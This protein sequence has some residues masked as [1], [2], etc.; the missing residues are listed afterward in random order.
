MNYLNVLAKALYDNVAESPDE[1][2]FRKG[3]IMTVLERD[4]QG[5]DGW[6][7]CSLHGR[8]GI[9]PGNRLKLL[10]GMYDS[11]QQ[12]AMP[13]TPEPASCPSSIQ[14]P[15]PPLSAYA[16]PSPATS[17][18]TCSS[19]Y[20]VKPL[21]SAQYTSMHPAYSSPAQP[22][23]DS[24]YMMPPSHG[25]K[26]SPQSVYQIP[27][28]P[29]GLPPGPP[30]KTSLA[31]R[32]Y[33]SPGQDIYQVPPSLGPGPG[34]TG[35]TGAGQDVYQVPPSMEKRNWESSTKP[36][37]KV[38]VPT[39]VGQVYVY[40]TLKSD[41][42][43]YDVP[44]RHQPP[45]QQDIYDVPPTRQ[46]YNT[47]V[48]DTPPMVVKGPSSGRD[49]YD[50]PVGSDKHTQQTV[51][52]FPPSVSK[53]VPDAH[54]IR[55]ET[56][57]VPPHFA[58]LKPVPA[59]PGQ[60]PH[61]HLL[62][63]DDEPPIPEDVYDVPPPIL[64]DK[65]YR[66]D[67]DGVIQHPQDIYDIPASLRSG[68]HSAQDVYDFP[69][70]REEKGGERGDNNI[71]DV[72]PQVM[73]DAQSTSEDLSL[74]FKR[75]SASSTGSTR[76][77]HSASSL[78]MVPVRDS[79]SSSSLPGSAPGKPLIL[80]LE[81]A[82]ERLSRLQQAVESSVSLMMSF[83]TGNWRSSAQLEGNLPAIHQAADRVRSAVRDFLE[84]A[85]GAVANSAQATDRSLQTKLFRQVGKMEEVFQSLIQHSQGLDAI[86]WSHTGLAAPP[87]GGDDLDRLIMT[88]R[89]IPDDAKQLASFLHGNASLLFKRNNRQQQQLPLPPIPGEIS[90]H[91]TG[92]GSG[93]YQGGEKVHIQ[94]RPLPSPP[95]FSAAEEEE[96]ME[97]PYESTEEGWMEDYDYVHLQ[98]K[99]EF[100]KNQKQLLEKGN[101]SRHKTQLEQQQIKQF[102]RLEQEVSRPINN[103]MTGWVPPPL[104][105]PANQQ[106][107]NGSG[108]SS[109]C[110][111]SSKLCHGDRQ[112]LLFYQEQC[113]QNVTTV[114]NAIDAFFT[115]VNSN[116]PPKIFVAHSK[117]VILSAHKL[118][119]IGDTLSRQAKGP[120]VRARVGQSSNTL[121]EKLKDIVISTK[122]AALQYPSPG[123]TR[124]MT[125][126]VRELAG[127]TQHFRMVLGQLLVM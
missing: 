63:D 55:E 84:F 51:Y 115:A 88:A 124:E 30:S 15:L 90:G 14:R 64:T 59:P 73:R 100:E 76:S 72:P 49:I 86:S 74:S 69:R 24:V 113:E 95:K 53:D 79:S 114:T 118:V 8:Q 7:L 106:A 85:R 21:P 101:I 41:Q 43:E 122:A 56:Y 17:S 78:D 40:D 61:N 34:H 80:D 121:C 5:L 20:P 75:L 37:G 117:F 120:E 96:G 47:Q 35:G 103:D 18:A 23:L 29:S 25:P 98:G 4:T 70:D 67:R 46:Q 60:Y 102:E 42:D 36:L 28:G 126:R 65:R 9:V 6:W 127:C 58:K 38:V 99:E 50:T 71:Y 33:H 27:S 10:V 3:D 119:F 92:S 107:Q 48:Y 110:S 22:N 45:G 112:L 97:R 66:A 83:I 11:K 108:G 57:D 82:M 91:M 13:S 31:Q 52:D 2:S 16:K 12:Q 19:G 44:P 62:D 87:P 77:N 89:G 125:D 32:Q 105:P 94:S 109:S 104:H 1:L 54:P 93:S 123:A 68:G 111:S 26:P 116:Q 81:Q 39:R